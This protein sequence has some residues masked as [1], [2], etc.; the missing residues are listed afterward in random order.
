M[1]ATYSGVTATDRSA[2][3]PVWRT[4]A[5]CAPADRHDSTA[6]GEPV[7]DG[8]H[9]PLAHDGVL[10]ASIA[11]HLDSHEVREIDDPS[12][13]RAA[14]A[15]VVAPSVVGSDPVD[16][17]PDVPV[18]MDGVPGDVD[19]FDG[20]M[21]GVAGGAALLLCRRAATLR[22]HGG[23]WAF[24]GGRVDD[25]ESAEQTARRELHEELG[26]VLPDDAVLGRLDD[27]QTR[28]GFVIT[29]VVMWSDDELDLV[30]D[31]VEVAY[32]YH[33]GIHELFRPGSPRFTPIPESDRPVVQLLMSRE[34]VHA[35][36]AAVLLQFRWVAIE[37]RAGERVNH[38]EQP[39]FAWR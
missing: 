26:V 18:S 33:I 12:A 5:A 36:T 13:R 24:P 11:R 7:T 2:I 6:Y 21:S 8:R 20:T 35:P 31:P 38:L 1:L 22:R 9:E 29:P 30:P 19:G 25:G 39:V 16:P 17:Y 4:T 15:V 34:I 14:V 32:A 23:Q 37:G 3:C 10:R 28:S 27:Y